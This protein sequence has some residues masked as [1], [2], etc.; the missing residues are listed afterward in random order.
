M[1]ILG[2][3]ERMTVIIGA[4]A[5]SILF[6]LLM[7]ILIVIICCCCRKKRGS[8]ASEDSYTGTKLQNNTLN[9][10]KNSY[11]YQYQQTSTGLN[12]NGVH[13]NGNGKVPYS[14]LENGHAENYRRHHS[15]KMGVEY[16]GLLS[17]EE[18]DSLLMERTMEV[19]Y[20]ST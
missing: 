9:N 3:D 11:S 17:P 12:G 13:S 16:Q 15:N 5:A 18:T 20:I 10:S 6:I 2:H 8:E 7:I 19:K 4:T 1:N 14:E